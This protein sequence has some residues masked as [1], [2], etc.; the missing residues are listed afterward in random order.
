MFFSH[1]DAAQ[2]DIQMEID[3]GEK[4][5]SSNDIIAMVDIVVSYP[6]NEYQSPFRHQPW[7]LS[8]SR[9]ST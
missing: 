3:D 2:L 8:D 9:E 1:R 4:R 6:G 5:L 7:M